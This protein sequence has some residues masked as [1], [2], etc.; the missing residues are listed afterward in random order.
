M[1][2]G[3]CNCNSSTVLLRFVTNT[4]PGRSSIG[5]GDGEVSERY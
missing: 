4:V 3:N 2:S 5:R 1:T